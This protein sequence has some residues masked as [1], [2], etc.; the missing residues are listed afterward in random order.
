[1]A[2][3]IKSASGEVKS[4]A[5]KQ[6]WELF[7]EGLEEAPGIAGG[8]TRLD[9]KI[10]YHLDRAPESARKAIAEERFTDVVNQRWLPAFYTLPLEGA[11]MLKPEAEVDINFTGT[12][13]KV[14]IRLG[15]TEV[16]A[17][18]AK[19]GLAWPAALIR[20]YKAGLFQ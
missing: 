20:A 8:A 14:V 6:A 3:M 15:R 17:A 2:V 4:A 10:A 18:A 12:K 9:M 16:S 7:V 5:P 1:M 19:I 13:A 11:G